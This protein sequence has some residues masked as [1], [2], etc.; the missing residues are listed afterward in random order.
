MSSELCL[1]NQPS[2]ALSLL[3]VPSDLFVYRIKPTLFMQKFLSQSL[4]C[5]SLSSILSCGAHPLPCAQHYLAN[6]CYER[7]QCVR[8]TLPLAFFLSGNVFLETPDL[9]LVIFP[10]LSNTTF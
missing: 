6:S 2:G 1:L 8:G 4:T 5:A 3:P 10:E 7:A 9:P